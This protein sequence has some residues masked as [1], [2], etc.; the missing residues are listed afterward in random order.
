MHDILAMIA[1]LSLLLLAAFAFCA[2][3]FDAPSDLP[4]IDG[5]L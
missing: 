2:V 3:M 4:D 5:M 1:L